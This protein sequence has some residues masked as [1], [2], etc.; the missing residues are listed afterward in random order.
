M[1]KVIYRAYESLLKGLDFSGSVLE[2]GAIPSKKSLLCLPQLAAASER[3]GINLDGPH[4][5]DGFSI[6]Q[7]NSNSMPFPD[8][9]FD[10]VLCNAVIEHDPYFWKTVE[11]IKR[12][13][14]P[15]GLIVIGAPG[16]R[17]MSLDRVQAGFKRIAAPLV[18]SPIFN[19]LFTATIT[20]HVH[21]EPGDFYRFSPQA[22]REVIMAGLDKVE[23]RSIMLPPRLIAS[24]RKA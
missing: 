14:K 18:N 3:L 24:G 17:T 7:G 5:F 23:V 2:I 6:I 13:T 21:N 16:Y 19:A 8:D 11:E 20:F 10:M 22:F 9:Y 12:V 15:G 1:H 4:E